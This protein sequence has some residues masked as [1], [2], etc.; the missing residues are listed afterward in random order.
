MNDR[1][2]IHHGNGGKYTQDLIASVF[3]KN[4]NNPFLAQDTDAATI[5]NINKDLAFT[6]DSYVI[7][8]PFFPG[9]DIGK[10]SV[11]GTCND[12][13][14]SYAK[15]LYLSAGFIIEEGFLL[16]DLEKISQSMAD[17][18]QQAKI[19]IITG[20]T[21]VVNKGECDQIFINTAGIGIK[22]KQKNRLDEIKSGD[23]IIING[24]IGEHGMAV[25]SSRNDFPVE[26]NIQSDCA[27]LFPLIDSLSCFEIK[28]MRDVTRGGL[29]T[30]LNEITQKFQTGIIIDEKKVP[31]SQAVNSICDLFGFDPLYLANEGKVLLVVPENE[32]NRILDRMKKNPLGKNSR[33]I[34]EITD[35]HLHK[36]ILNTAI[37]GNRIIDTLIGDQL[38]RIC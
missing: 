20:D 28:F 13:A 36:V 10:L 22:N 23:K 8:P 19:Q 6:T 25:F 2:L 31:V 11:Y 21:K 4:Y 26:T 32:S 24:N 33:I 3:L 29:A 35:H 15:P 38:P 9:G 34:G 7:K 37:G 14:V 18:A 16:Q 12:L 1:I 5:Q 17:A 30:I 27:N